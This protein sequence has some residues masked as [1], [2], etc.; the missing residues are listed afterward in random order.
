MAILAA[1]DCSSGTRWD[2]SGNRQICLNCIRFSGF[3]WGALFGSAWYQVCP[4]ILY[5]PGKWKKH[6]LLWGGNQQFL[7]D[8]GI[9]YTAIAW[10]YEL[11][12]K[13]F[14]HE[15]KKRALDQQIRISCVS[16]FNIYSAYMQ[17]STTNRLSYVELWFKL[18]WHTN[19]LILSQKAFPKNIQFFLSINTLCVTFHPVFSLRNRSCSDAMT[20]SQRLVVWC[21]TPCWGVLVGCQVSDE[22]KLVVYGI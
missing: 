17:S 22:K 3:F 11:V 7:V 9:K 2:T 1:H 16:L 8:F 18:K 12:A 15:I 5:I 14:S 10:L 20:S 4:K 6:M 19:E 13:M 21:S